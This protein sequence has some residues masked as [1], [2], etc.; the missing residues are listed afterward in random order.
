MQELKNPVVGL[1]FL[2][3]LLTFLEKVQKSGQKKQTANELNTQK[4]KR[5]ELYG[6]KENMKTIEALEASLNSFYDTIID[7][8]RPKLWPTVSLA[9]GY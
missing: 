6:S 5:E 9:D 1:F 2:R 8:K 7:L 4:R 3:N